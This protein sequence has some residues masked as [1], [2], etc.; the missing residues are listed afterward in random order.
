MRVKWAVLVVLVCVVLAVASTAYA[1]AQ[2]RP[3]ERVSPAPEVNPN[4]VVWRTPEPPTNPQAGD[5]WVNPRDGMEMVY[6]AAGEFILG[7]SDAQIDEW[8]RENSDDDRRLF[9]GEQPQCRVNLHPFWIGK[10]EVT[11]AQY[12]EFCRATGRRFPPSPPNGWGGDDHPMVCVEWRDASA[13]AKWAGG[14]LP[15][16]LE[17][18]K[19]ARGTDGRIYPWGDEWD[20]RRCAN[21]A[22]SS[23]RP[24]NVGRFPAGRSPNGVMDMVGNTQEWCA[25]GYASRA[26]VF[27]ALGVLIPPDNESRKVLRGCSFR[28]IHPIAFRYAHRSWGRADFSAATEDIG[29]PGLV[30]IG[31]T[32]GFRC[33][34]DAE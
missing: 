17:W 19:A 7:T 1:A 31:D 33:A 2:E 30:Y 22:N 8:L 24:S 27:Y 9:S 5:V 14:R 16:E 12:R 4:A 29:I 23:R 18:E 3:T 20:D 13:Y 15:T 34:M 25:D 11:V 6:V 28:D 10:Y 21:S 26:Y 32:A